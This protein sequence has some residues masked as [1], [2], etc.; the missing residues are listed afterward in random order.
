MIWDYLPAI[1][2]WIS[3]DAGNRRIGLKEKWKLTV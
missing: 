2:F 1:S 3:G